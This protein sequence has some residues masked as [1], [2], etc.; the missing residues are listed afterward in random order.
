M[1]KALLIVALVAMCATGADG[2][3]VTFGGVGNNTADGSF[4]TMIANAAPMTGGYK[5]GGNVANYGGLG[6]MGAKE[7][8]STRSLIRF[9]VASLGSVP[10][11][12]SVTLRLFQRDANVTNLSLF[13]VN[14]LGANP[15]SNWEEGTDTGSY[16]NGWWNRTSWSYCNRGISDSWDG[17]AGGG[18]LGPTVLA[19]V[20]ATPGVVGA[21][22]DFVFTGSSAFLTSLL[23]QWATDAVTDWGRGSF[24]P[25]DTNVSTPNAG[26]LLV[27]NGTTFYSSEYATTSLQP[28]LIVDV[29]PEPA[30]MSL[31]ALG[32]VAALIRRKK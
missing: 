10:A 27:G 14:D 12:N 29:V 31:L 30:T 8:A 32:G 22:V 25:P 28:L 6:W 7:S 26:M 18:T 11:V 20:A 15:N 5:F 1:K 2:A 16:S 24:A 19:T 4:E 9:D 23:N 17:G 3:I 21:P 13:L